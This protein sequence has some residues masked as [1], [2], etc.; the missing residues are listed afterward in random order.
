M[1]M[2]VDIFANNTQN[3]WPHNRRSFILF[4]IGGFVYAC[5]RGGFFFFVTLK[6]FF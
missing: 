2:L 5:K 4:E 3:F 1:E 6:T